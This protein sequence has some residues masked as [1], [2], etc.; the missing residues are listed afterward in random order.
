MSIYSFKGESRFMFIG[1]VTELEA[2]QRLKS[3]KTASLV[4]VMGRR[5]IGKSTLIEEFGKGFESFFEIQGIAPNEKSTNQD[6]LDHFADR[7]SLKLGRR[8]E[9]FQNWTEAFHSLAQATR[10]GEHL[11]LLDE[12]S[13]MGRKDALFSSRLKDAWDLQFKRNPKLI[14]VLCGSVSSWIEA[15]I[16]KNANFEGRISMEI[17]LGELTLSEI[18]QFWHRQNVRLSTRE[19]MLLLSITG[20]VPKYLEEIVPNESVSQTIVRL[21][22]EPTGMLFS[23]FDKIFHEIF[24]RKGKTYEKIVRAC[25]EKKL[26]PTELAHQLGTAPNSD[27]SGHIHAL[28]LSG[29]LSRDFYFHPNGEISKLGHLRLKDNYTRF[30]LKHIEP[31]RHK[32]QTG[33]KSIRSLSELK[34]FESTMGFQFENLILANRVRLHEILKISSIDV[35]SSAPYVQRKKAKTKGACQIDLLIHTQ[36]DVFYLCEFKCRKMI[37]KTVIKEVRKKM[38]VL[39]IP[40]RSALKPVLIYEGELHPRDEDQIK[41]FFYRVIPFDDFL[42][43]PEKRG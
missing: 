5:R 37:D 12:I 21:C 8:K 35:L 24:E 36:L 40:K 18:Q 22:F 41:E 38:D 19:K 7:L 9:H 11:I 25:I 33:A 42:F 32:I 29:F 10:E 39:S 17:N 3:K 34:N 43:D 2:L 4:C 15:N 26:S 16:S 20:G 27:L 13:W 6:Q 31:L 14:L 23:E 28:V 30:Y 1:R